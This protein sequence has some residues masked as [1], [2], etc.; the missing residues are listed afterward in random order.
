M[1]QQN[2]YIRGSRMKR[3]AQ[4]IREKMHDKDV[5]LRVKRLVAC[6][7][8]LSLLGMIFVSTTYLFRNTKHNRAH[9]VGIKQEGP[10]DMVY[11][12]GSATY[13]YWQPLKAWNDCGFTSYNFATDNVQAENLKYYI[14]EV[15]KTHTPELF[16]VDIRP[17]QYWE[18][19]IWENGIRNGIDSF[20]LSLDRLKFAHS[21]LS[22]RTIEQD[23]DILSYYIDIIKYHSNYEVLENRE[24][25]SYIWNSGYSKSKGYEALTLHQYLHT[26]TDT[27]TNMQAELPE[28]CESILIDLLDFCKK[29]NLNVL[30][31]VSPYKITKDDNAKYNTIQ[32]VIESYGFAY[33]NSNA[34]YE[35]M[36]IDF[37]TDL[38]NEGHVNVLGAEKYTT[39]LE[40]YIDEKYCLKDHREDLAY[41]QWHEKYVEFSSS[42]SE[43]REYVSNLIAVAKES[44]KIAEEMSETQDVEK[45]CLLAND[46][47]FTLLMAEKG[48]TMQMPCL[49]AERKILEHWGIN[50][51]KQNKGIVRVTN[52][53]TM[54][55]SNA[56]YQS[57]VNAP[58]EDTSNTDYLINVSEEDASIIYKGKE[59]CKQ[60][61]G[62][63]IVVIDNNYGRVV[64]SVT[65][66]TDE[67]QHLQL[68]R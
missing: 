26:P 60:N 66:C 51:E 61:M 13:G 29:K 36:N 31:V 17:F 43:A 55:Y 53:E 33:M 48:E 64:D 40:N 23:T 28:T 32:E 14:N 39:F 68:L 37:A 47:R 4:V 67:S 41:Q 62:L 22:S 35:E 30:F 24:N 27:W 2:L 6:I 50:L 25:W 7:C 19:R 52:G 57:E 20:D 12:G 56:E 63:N 5:V 10:L 11:V 58:E 38:S 49:Q 8:F 44:E 45:W 18:T 9:I 3:W 34:Y 59:Y 42:E 1:M 21:Y 54:V 65:I 46:S 15:L 16:V